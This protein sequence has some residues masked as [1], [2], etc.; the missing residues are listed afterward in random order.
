[1]NKEEIAK[2]FTEI[3]QLMD[4]VIFAFMQ[5]KM[6]YRQAE[7]EVFRMLQKERFSKETKMIENWVTHI[8]SSSS[9][10]RTGDAA[11]VVY[12]DDFSI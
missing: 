8:P 10:N 3:D 2:K 11:T 7:E 4:Q 5:T 9:S 1:M 6:S 12:A